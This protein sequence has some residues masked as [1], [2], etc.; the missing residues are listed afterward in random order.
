MGG[1]GDDYDYSTDNDVVK[2]TAKA[3]NVSHKRDYVE[4]RERLPPPK[5]KILLTKAEFPIVIAVDVTGSMRTLPALIFEKLCLLY[6]EVLY[7]LPEELKDTCEI[8]FAAIGDAYTDSYP[9]QITDFG[10]G[11][12]LDENIKSLYPEGG[13]GGQSRESYELMAYYYAKHCATPD[14]LKSPRPLFIFIGDEGYYSKI[15]R[16]QI[17]QLIG[18]KPKTDLISEDIFNDLKSKFDVYILRVEYSRSG[19]EEGIHKMW[20]K[21]LGPERVLMLKE[22]RRV[23]DVILGIIAASVDRFDGFKERIELRQTPE[24]VDDVYSSLDGLKV[25]NKSYMY[26]FQALKCPACGS[27]LDKVPEHK[28]PKRCPVCASLI[29]RI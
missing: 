28:K 7:F 25:E 29:V 16:S 6:N 12:E 20:K 21:A 26:K 18:D 8:S 2:K 23:V 4:T 3:Y 10:K 15:N 19:E 11:F 1:Y 9:I 5:N 27:S 22:P 24:Q 17:M 13:G 14:I